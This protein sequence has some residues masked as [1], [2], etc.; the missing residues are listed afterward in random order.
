[1]NNTN[2]IMENL[3]DE[4]TSLPAVDLTKPQKIASINDSGCLHAERAKNTIWPNAK[5]CD[6]DKC[7][8]CFN[9]RV[10]TLD[11]NISTGLIVLTDVVDP[12]VKA[13]LETRR[14]IRIQEQH[15]Y[16][17]IP[18]PSISPKLKV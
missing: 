9:K 11:E 15:D 5:L 16:L 12:A 18:Q 7:T 2:L 3:L 17:R 14:A 10:A 8:W 1:M 4:E 13:A 6:D